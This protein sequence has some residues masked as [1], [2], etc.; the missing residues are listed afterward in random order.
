[1]FAAK[2]LYDAGVFATWANNDTSVLQFL[3]PLI[4]TDDQVDELIGVVRKAFS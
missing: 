2:V 1:M 3:P 4:L